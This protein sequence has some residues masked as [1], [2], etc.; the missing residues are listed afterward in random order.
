MRLSS[1]FT[2]GLAAT[3][4]SAHPGH[5]HA[6]EV[7]ERSAML[8]LMTRSDLSHCAA[9]I[10]ARGLEARSVARRRALVSQLLKR[11]NLDG[12]CFYPKWTTGSGANT[13]RMKLTK[14]MLKVVT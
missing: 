5:D 10:K 13:D 12:K 1:I 3:A 6:A 9:K 11:G 4:V 8:S 7:T 14:P 2:A